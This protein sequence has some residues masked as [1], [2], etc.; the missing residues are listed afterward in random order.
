MN[1]WRGKS[2]VQ[3]AVAERGPERRDRP[4]VRS[5]PAVRL[6]NEARRLEALREYNLLDTLPEQVLDDLTTLASHIC[7]TPISLISLIDKDRQWFK[8][9]VGL[10][11]S[12]LPRDI[13][14]CGHTILQP[15]MFTVP[16]ATQDE[17]FADNPL[18][19]GDLQIRFYAGMPLT[20]PEGHA[21]GTLC[22]IDHKPR[23]LTPLQQESLQVLARQAMTQFEL[24]RQM[25]EVGESEA[26]L[27]LALDAAQM[28]TFEWDMAHNRVTWSRGHEKLWGFK[29]GEFDGTFEAFTRR[30]HPDDLPGLNVEIARCLAAR[31]TFSSDFRVIWLDGTVHWIA[32]RGEFSFD[33]RG[34][35]LRMRG[36]VLE[37]TEQ[38][39]AE[40]ALARRAQL[41]SL[42][43][44]VAQAL[45]RAGEPRDIMQQISEA[46]VMHLNAAF[47]RVWTLN[48]AE[49]TLELQA[50]AGLYTN[51]NGLQSRV[52]MGEMKIGRIA[53]NRAAH[54]TNEVL[55]DP[56]IS[57]PEWA[58]REGITAFAGY[59]LL[60][61]NR[62][63]GVVA[64]FCRSRL[65]Q[66]ILQ[67]LAHIADGL[68]Q[69]ILRKLAEEALHAT[70]SQL[71]QYTHEL[72]GRVAQRTADLKGMNEQL[73]AFV[74]SIA[75]DLRAPLRALIG[76]S[77]MLVEDHSAD[78]DEDAKE[79][80]NRIQNSSG[81]M[82]KLVIDLLAYGR[83]ASAEIE[84]APVSVQEQWEI[85]LSQCATQIEQTN[86]QVETI[87]Q[88][89][90]VRAHAATLGQC[91]ANL[92]S[93]ALKFIKAG[94]K[95]QVRFW[96]DDHGHYVRLWI[97]DNGIGI[98][99]EQKER[100]FR[101]FE[102]LQSSR[103]PGTGIGLSIVRKGIERM[104]GKVGVESEPNKGSRFWIELPKTF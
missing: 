68:A 30:V 65:S 26:R 22:V 86:A 25:R 56:E 55:H 23:Q 104:G 9:R 80:L 38:K 19:T 32:A 58:K 71:E 15:H 81:F 43:A 67:E 100:V 31:E 74:Y 44:D 41:A 1:E 95:P 11:T 49:N 66:E 84:L 16:D 6:P 46:L 33:A 93:N 98:A 4:A 20:S 28:G 63:M 21:L 103:Y 29:P 92:L 97:A 61:E 77:Q 27:R 13:S 83:A 52:K 99:P 2:N 89:P 91:L 96:S 82:D 48:E 50:S 59:P 85:A 79:L 53:Q 5:Q 69:W 7:G 42:R 102:R 10:S 39:R 54:L 37:T 70:Q 12:E 51:L 87:G 35:P 78:L 90:T 57:D 47:A 62:V 8:S 36:A 3:E 101:V 73:E 14:F 72:E 24:R 75:H 60:V 17:R 18:V 88:L 76:Y 45:T 40:Q 34:H 94:A 64:L